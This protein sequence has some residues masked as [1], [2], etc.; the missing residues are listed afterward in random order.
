MD[1]SGLAILLRARDRRRGPARRRLPGGRARGAAARARG[2]RRGGAL[3]D[4][5]RRAGRPEAP[6]TDWDLSGRAVLV[7]GAARGIGAETA[8]RL[9]ARGARVALVGL[10]PTELARVAAECPGAVVLRGRRDRSRRAG[11]RGRRHGRGVR[12]HRRGRRER[13]HRRRRAGALDGPGRVRA[14]RSRSTCSASGAPCAPACRTSSSAAA[15]C[16]VASL[17]AVAHSPG[18]AAVRGAQVRRRGVRR[19]RCASRCPA[20]GRRGLRVL[21]AGSTPT[22]SAGR[23]RGRSAPPRGKLKGPSAA[24]ARSPTRPTRSK[25]VAWVVARADRRPTRAGCRA[26]AGARS[27]AQPTSTRESPGPWPSD[28]RLALEQGG[29][30]GRGARTRRSA[31]AAPADRA[32]RPSSASLGRHG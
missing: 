22:W 21:L 23:T 18:M 4:P 31:P 1:S 9:A 28:D 32:S 25:A 6:M 11:R 19:T 5:R 27:A 2:A 12:R 20:R 15:T 17:A 3:R 10:E 7:T 8:R 30:A 29:A 16:S 26:A 13:R 14:R 24:R